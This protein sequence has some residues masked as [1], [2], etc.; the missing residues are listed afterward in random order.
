MNKKWNEKEIRIELEKLDRITGLDGASLIVEFV[1]SKIKVG[2]FH[3]KNGKP[4]KFCFSK[5]FFSDETF[6]YKLAV[7]AIRHEYAHYIDFLNNGNMGHGKSWKLCCNKVKAMPI[8]ILNQSMIDFYRQSEENEK[9]ANELINMYVEGLVIVHPKF[10]EG[11]ID[12]VEKRD[13]GT[14]TINFNCVGYKT[15]GLKWVIDNCQRCC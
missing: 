12:N 8:R 7:D 2:S 4:H 14:I 5:N 15:L 10:G 3:I 6:P 9:Q 13:G 11:V 1:K